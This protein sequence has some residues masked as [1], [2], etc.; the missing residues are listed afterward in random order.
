MLV[1][2][3]TRLPPFSSILEPVQI[4]NLELPRINLLNKPNESQ[5]NVV[6]DLS[7][8]PSETIES[9][10]KL[11]MDNSSF[12]NTKLVELSSFYKKSNQ[13]PIYKIKLDVEANDYS[14]LMKQTLTKKNNNTEKTNTTP[15]KTYRNPI[16]SKIHNRLV[17]YFR[18]N[19]TPDKVEKSKIAKE[20]NLDIQ[21]VKDW[22]INRRRRPDAVKY[23][24]E[25]VIVDE[26][27]NT[28][29]QMHP[30][31]QH[32]VSTENPSIHSAS[33]ITNTLVNTSSR[34]LIGASLLKFPEVVWIKH[35]GDESIFS[36]ICKFEV[37]AN[38]LQKT[39][40]FNLE[41][42]HAKWRVI[43]GLNAV[44][45]RSLLANDIPSEQKKTFTREKQAI[46]KKYVLNSKEKNGSSIPF[47]SVEDLQ[48]LAC[49]TNLSYKQVND[50]FANYRRRKA[51][52]LPTTNS[53][54]EMRDVI[55]S[56]EK[57]IPPYDLE[58][59]MT[60]EAYDPNQQ[61]VKRARL[62]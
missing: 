21:Q 27:L 61:K 45:L 50:W 29:L 59:Q 19:S 1:P 14:N 48:K 55:S 37:I 58:Q 6:R 30:Q 47:T 35:K 46:L 42:S 54:D 4:E 60:I 56:V 24:E 23:R 15:E 39:Y 11:S 9:I 44:S 8:T 2:Q 18:Q 20:L 52:D 17:D 49:E 26:S 62:E 36:K 31:A 12:I 53:S 32:P 34:P 3:T 33:S 51:R 13:A 40:R 57:Q 16:T 25:K 41:L 10:Y 28:E 7:S 43:Q 38:G 22:F 5:S